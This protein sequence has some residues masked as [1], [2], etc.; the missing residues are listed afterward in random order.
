MHWV[1]ML[2][3]D[4]QLSQEQIQRFAMAFMAIIPLLILIGIAIVMIP[5]WF[6]L[7]KAG[8]TPWLSLLCLI[9]SL[10]VLVLLYVLAFAEWKVVPAPQLG[11]PPPYPPPPQPPLPPRA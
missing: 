5:C 8:F 3:Q 11:Y 4:N 2:L 6:I 1:A 10:G 7:K 9:P